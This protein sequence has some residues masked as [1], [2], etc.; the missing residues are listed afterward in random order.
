[1]ADEPGVRHDK[2]SICGSCRRSNSEVQQEVQPMQNGENRVALIVLADTET[3]ADLG[4]VTNAMMAARE[5]K[6]AGDEVELVFDGAGTRW[7]GKLAD[8]GHKSHG[9]Y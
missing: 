1:M 6:E 2:P 3:H 5:F 4:R 7:L 8:P 9:L